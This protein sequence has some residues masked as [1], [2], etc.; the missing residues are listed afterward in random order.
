M[1]K[2]AIIE[3][4]DDGYLCEGFAVWDD[5]DA[6]RPGILVSPEWGKCHHVRSNL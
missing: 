6:K 2:S 4:K 3:Y 1:Q 5:A